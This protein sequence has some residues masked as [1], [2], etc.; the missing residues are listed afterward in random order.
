MKNKIAIGILF[1]SLTLIFVSCSSDKKV[2]AKLSTSSIE[3]S[4]KPVDKVEADVDNSNVK[5]EENK[6]LPVTA[7]EPKV[8]APT[9]VTV[10]KKVIVID[11]GH[12]NKSNLEKEALKPGSSE[13]KIKDGGGAEGIVTKTPEYLV[14][15]QV[16]MKLKTLL[17]TKGYQVVMTKTDNSVSLGNIEWANI[18]NQANAALVIRIH[19]D[20]SDNSSVNGASMLVPAVVNQDTKAIYEESKRCGTIVL[21]SLVNYV[22]MKNRGVVEHSDMTGFNWTKV[23][24][25]LVEMGF[26]SNANEDRLLSSEEYE[27]KLSEGLSEG[28]SSAIVQ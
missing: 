20:S 14:N 3:I 21:N 22:G 24:V 12:A 1:I 23:P 8:T 18:G 9:V 13:L 16:S 11:P 26:L 27:N 6:S 17:E 5:S 7:P 2:K 15:M 19:A 10:N 28:I 25:I 4:E